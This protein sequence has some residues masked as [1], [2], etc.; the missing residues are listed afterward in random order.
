[1]SERSR[2]ASRPPRPEPEYS[3]DADRVDAA[4]GEE[5]VRHL[6]GM[7]TVLEALRAEDFPMSRADV[8]Y[9]VGDVD[10]EDGRGG[11]VPVRQ[12]TESVPSD[13]FESAE[14]V[15]RALRRALQRGSG[16]AA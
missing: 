1:M 4:A 12:L 6:K 11:V 14:E 5:P 10:V 2:E 13:R 7:S 15:V 9:A 16:K 3:E 8:D